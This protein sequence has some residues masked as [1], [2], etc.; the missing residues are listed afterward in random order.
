MVGKVGA[1]RGTWVSESSRGLME[2]GCHA[3]SSEWEGKEEGQKSP[4]QAA[5]VQG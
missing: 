2:F 4:E 3:L 1:G 5:G